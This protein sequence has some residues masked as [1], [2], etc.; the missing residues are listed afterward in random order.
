M[1]PLPVITL[2][3]SLIGLPGIVI[4]FTKVEPRITKNLPENSGS[5]ALD[6][7]FFIMLIGVVT[8][9][10]MLIIS[11]FNIIPMLF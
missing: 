7:A 4:L 5:T 9:G 10:I 6:I 2:I 1:P 11:L 3:I 8:F